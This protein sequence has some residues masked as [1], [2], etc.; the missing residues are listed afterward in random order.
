M[1]LS[2]TE[3]N[4]G[5]QATVSISNSS[6]TNMDVTVTITNDIGGEI[7]V[8]VPMD[9]TGNGSANFTVPEWDVANVSDGRCDDIREPI[10]QQAGA[11]E[12]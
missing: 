2:V 1:T 10:N 7:T 12:G 5:G 8:Q 4:A 6:R 3:L 11:G 9:A